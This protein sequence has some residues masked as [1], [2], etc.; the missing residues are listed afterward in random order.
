MTLVDD[1]DFRWQIADCRLG[2]GQSGADQEPGD[3]FD[4]LLRRGQANAEQRLLDDVL[5]TLERQREV[6]A[7][8]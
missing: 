4:R 3:L 6:S 5:Q 1:R 7:A 8:A 2:S